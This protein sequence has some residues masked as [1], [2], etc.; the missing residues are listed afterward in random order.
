MKIL[1]L[2][3]A[4]YLAGIDGRWWFEGSSGLR[5]SEFTGERKY[6]LLKAGGRSPISVGYK[7]NIVWRKILKIFLRI[8][9]CLKCNFNFVN[10]KLTC[11][12]FFSSL[13]LFS[14]LLL[15]WKALISFCFFDMLNK[16]CKIVK[17]SKIY[18]SLFIYM[19]YLNH[20][21]KDQKVEKYYNESRSNKTP[22]HPR[23]CV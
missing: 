14:I 2:K 8:F 9:K 20:F 21:N 19:N 12:L 15:E 6:I 16:T 10:I 1:D 13:F 5:S 11:F 18:F 17:D 7:Q 4:V 23:F 22:S 3:K